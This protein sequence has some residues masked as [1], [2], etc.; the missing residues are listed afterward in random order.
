MSTGKIPVE[1]KLDFEKA[2][3]NMGESKEDGRVAWAKRTHGDHKDFGGILDPAN[4]PTPV[5]GKKYYDP[6][7]D[8]WKDHKG[9]I[10]TPPG[11]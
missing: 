7:E 6:A 4:I 9:E 3:I 5:Q 2:Y 1:T 10:T 11:E 8:D